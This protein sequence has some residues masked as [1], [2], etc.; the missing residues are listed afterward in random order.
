MI[1]IR[2][3]RDKERLKLAASVFEQASEGIFILDGNF[4][5][6]EVNPKYEQLTGL[7]KQ[8]IVNKQLF[9]ITKQNKQHHHNFHL[10]I[11]DTLRA[12]QEYE[13]E[14]QETYSSEKCVFYGCILMQ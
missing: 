2:K 4:N 14:F 11:L 13:G 6:V 5:Y 9:E 10:S 3:K 12:E 7:N 1:S 8:D